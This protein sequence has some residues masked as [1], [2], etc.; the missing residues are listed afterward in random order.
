[1]KYFILISIM[2]LMCFGCNGQPATLTDIPQMEYG[3]CEPNCEP[4]TKPE[5][6]YIMFGLSNILEF[7]YVEGEYYIDY[8]DPDAFDL[9]KLAYGS[10]MD[11]W[12]T[13]YIIVQLTEKDFF[14]LRTD[15]NKSEEEQWDITMNEK[16]V[17]KEVATPV[18]EG[19]NYKY[20]LIKNPVYA[21]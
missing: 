17:L 2:A 18:G 1:M 8:Y 5:T 4:N 21:E 15:A 16:W 12:Y 13:D 7:I 10:G 6:N 20:Y 19:M 9:D 14:E 3:D 11:K